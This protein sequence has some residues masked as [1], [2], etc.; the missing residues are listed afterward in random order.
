MTISNSSFSPLELHFEEK[1]NFFN[2]SV[3]PSDIWKT[4]LSV[5]HTIHKTQK[6]YY[7]LKN[8][9]LF[10]KFLRGAKASVSTFSLL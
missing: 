5:L 9:L 3:V 7:I 8:Y 1:I 4:T 2:C 10:N 6:T